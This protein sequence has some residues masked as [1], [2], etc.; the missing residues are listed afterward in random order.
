MQLTDFEM[1]PTEMPNGVQ[2]ILDFG[3]YHLSIVQNEFSYGGT[4]G[5]YEIGVFIAEDGVATDMTELP[6]ITDEGESVKGFLSLV[7]V[8]AIIKKMYTI[9]GKIPV[10][11]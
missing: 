7:D 9:T 3:K 1:M 11:I 4:K 2:A 5:F 6:G 8:D 10:Q